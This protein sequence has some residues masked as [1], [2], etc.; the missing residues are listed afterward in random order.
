MLYMFVDVL[1]VHD[2]SFDCVQPTTHPK[3]LMM[4]Y[5]AAHPLACS[6]VVPFYWLLQH[7]H[8]MMHSVLHMPAMMSIY[9]SN[10]FDGF[11][12]D[13]G[14]VVQVVTFPRKAT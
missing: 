14:F 11:E 8:N 9:V 1:N 5:E 4:I 12:P 13:E 2:H 7:W 6:A 3:R 10:T